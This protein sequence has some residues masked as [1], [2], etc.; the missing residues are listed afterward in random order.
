MIQFVV[1]EFLK[2]RLNKYMK[3]M[4]ILILDSDPTYDLMIFL[5][6]AISKIISTLI[7]YPYTTIRTKQHVNKKEH[8]SL[9]RVLS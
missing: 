3:G 9:K 5:I 8:I 6:G 7:T 1:Y 2:V 4:F